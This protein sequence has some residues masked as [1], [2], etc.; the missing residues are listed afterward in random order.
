MSR[1]NLGIW[2]K[3]VAPET[4]ENVTKRIGKVKMNYAD[5]RPYLTDSLGGNFKE[6][7]KHDLDID[8]FDLFKK[9]FDIESINTIEILMERFRKL[10]NQTEAF[11]KESIKMVNLIELER[12]GGSK[13]I[14]K[15]LNFLKQTYSDIEWEE[16]V[17][18]FNHGLF[19]LPEKVRDKLKN[20]IVLDIGSYIGDS[21][22][23]LEEFGF[24]RIISFDISQKSTLKY[25]KCISK[26][27]RNPSI[28]L[29]ELLALSDTVGDVIKLS[30]NGSAGMSV[31]RSNSGEREYEVL[32]S[33]VDEYCKSKQVIPQC[34][35]AD[36]EGFAYKMVKGAKE[37]IITHKP[38]LCLAIY[39]NP[40]EFFEI[41]LVLQEW[42]PSYKFILR[43]MTPKIER[44]HCHS[45]VFLIA[46][47]DEQS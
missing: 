44:N 17:G 36:M 16:S 6:F 20:S 12:N 42:V 2:F 41:K 37:T 30:D 26:F 19:F 45:E 27:G 3:R 8:K 29:H 31:L 10:P 1:S 25:K 15:R 5:K 38:V 4:Y 23:M 35:K 43:K 33:T 21:A 11:N 24:S 34:I 13:E 7:I 46:Y 9:G 22:L 47:H 32:S 40:E 18:Y 14:R 39:H 28:F